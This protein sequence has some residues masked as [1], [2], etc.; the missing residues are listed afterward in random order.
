MKK[1]KYSLLLTLVLVLSV[2]LAACSGGNNTDKKS[3]GAKTSNAAQ[4][5]KIL[6]KSEIPTLDSVKTTDE[7]GFNVLNSINEGLYT[8]DKDGSSVPALVDGEP[9]VSEDGKTV[10]FKLIDA[11][12]SNGDPVTA[13]DFVFAWQRAIDPATAS[14]YGPYMMNG[15][16]AGAQEI[17]DAAVAKKDFDLNTLGIKAIDEKTLE[18]K[19]EK[20]LP[21]WKDLMAFPTFYPQ[22]EKFVKEKGNAYASN[23]ENLISNGAFK[24]AAW[25][26][27]TAMEWT[28]EKNDTYRDADAITLKKITFNVVKDNNAQVNAFEGGEADITDILSSDLV[29]QYQGDER[30][31]SALQPSVYWIKMNYKNKALANVNIRE[32]LAKAFNKED[33]AASILN[34]GSIAANY[35]VP[36]KFVTTP[37]GKDFREKNGDLIVF[38]ADEAKAAWEKGLAELGLDKL[39]LSYLGGDTDSAKK[40]D[41]YI[42]NQLETNLPG[43]KVNLESVPFAIRLDRAKAGNYDLL[44]S[45]WGP[46]YPD[47]MTFADLWLTDSPN[48]EMSYSSAKYDGLIKKAEEAAANPEEYV[49]TLQEAERVFL[50]E[51]Y[52]VAPTYQRADNIL[53]SPKVKGLVALPFGPNY[54][55]KW[56][57]VEE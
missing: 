44:H 14:E 23:A 9:E 47:A 26:G 8:Q 19:F 32:A 46:D 29:P 56:I 5:I 12:W 15:K 53:I 39:E 51:D 52:G 7:I 43:L 40:Q 25:K 16:I 55:Y 42:V 37:D 45:G 24:L 21:Y 48:N 41:E 20:V 6:S 18:V 30:M 4:E 54:S 34:N 2:F 38:N 36:D 11:K 27:P 35:F 13:Q 31:V 33:L 10:T 1:S 17:T 3:D 28:L 22:N 50:A 57:T 49:A